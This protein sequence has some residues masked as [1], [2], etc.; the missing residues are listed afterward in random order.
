MLTKDQEQA[1]AKIEEWMSSKER[2]FRL[3][4]YAGTGKSYL[5]SFV[6]KKFKKL[7]IIAVSP[8]NKAANNLKNLLNA[9]NVALDVTTNAKLLKQ[10]PEIDLN[11][12]NENFVSFGKP[13]F[14]AYDL[15]IFDE[16]SMIGKDTFLEIQKALFL[17]KNT[18]ALFLG[19]LAQLPPIKE[20]IS[21]VCKLNLKFHYSLTEVVRYDG[22]IGKIAEKIRSNPIYNTRLY[23]FT[24]SEDKT[25]ICISFQ[26]LDVLLTKY[27]KSAKFVKNNDY[28]RLLAF[29]NKTC[30]FY[31]AA[32]RNKLHGRGVKDYNLGDILITKKPLFRLKEVNGEKKWII[33]INN[34]EEMKIVDKSEFKTF[35]INK[36]KFDCYLIPVI[37]LS[38]L[39]TTIQVLTTESC[40]KLEQ[41]LKVLAEKAVHA[42]ESKIKSFLW[43]QYYELQKTFDDVAFA[44]CLTTHKAQ[45]S[46]FDNVILDVADLNSCQDKQKIIYTALTRAKKCVF[47]LQ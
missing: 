31:N 15:I 37:T 30:E 1:L 7:N 38:G 46:T 11:T 20:E 8:T 45:G 5:V 29:K 41:Q 23:S 3:S 6:V 27:F 44:Y 43:H 2:Y 36:L 9:Q 25:V 17:T 16:F 33:L 28:I 40:L 12:G 19:D 24:N 18:K 47:I 4:G 14:D 13:S 21:P 42:K 10:L 26:E 22:E 35:L 39:K 34:S 32:V